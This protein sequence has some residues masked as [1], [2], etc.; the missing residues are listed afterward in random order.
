MGG[1]AEA[2]RAKE[3]LPILDDD[4]SLELFKGNST[5][6]PSPFLTQ[7]QQSTTESAR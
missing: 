6:V 3:W 2:L 1:V 5:L 4:F 7:V